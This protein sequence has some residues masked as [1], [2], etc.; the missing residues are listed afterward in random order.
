MAVRIPIVTDFDGKGLE[1]AFKAFKELETTGQKATFALKQAFIPATIALAGLTTGLTMA[2]KAAAEDDRAQ[3]ELERQI[4]ATTSATQEQVAASSD[5]IDTMQLQFAVADSELRP[6]LASLVRGSHDLGQAQ[7]DLVTVLDVSAATGKSVTEV[8]DAVS[9]AYAGNT[10]ALKQ[11]SPELYALIKDGASVD[12]VMQSL[13]DTMGG[14]ATAA[15]NSAEGQMKRL[16]LAFGEA[17]ESIGRAFLPVLEALLP[18][19]T[20]LA[21]IAQNNAPLI[22]GL[23][24]ALGVLAGGIVAAN[25]ALTAW[26]AVGVITTGI[27]YALATSFT[28]VQVATGIGI[29]AVVA[30]IGA[31]ALYKRELD[32]VKGAAAGTNLMP[33]GGGFIG[34]QVTDLPAA[35]QEGFWERRQKITGGAGAVSEA[36]DKMG[37]RIA[38]AR[39]EIQD[40]FNK[41]L[42]EAN[43]KLAQ[44][45][46]AY[47][48]YAK[49][50]SGSV[51]GTL[52]FT[53]ALKEATDAAGTTGKP[54]SFLGGLTVMAER[55]KLFGERI[56]TLLKMGLSESALRQVA[57]A[58]VEAG[59]YIA[60][61]L[62]NGGSE[63]IERTNELVASLESVADTLGIEAADQFYAAGV[64]QGEALVAGIQS[65]ID[66]Y[67]AILANPNL[68]L[69]QIKA[70]GAAA[71]ASL[72]E[73][74]IAP[75][76][77]PAFDV[78][79]FQRN[80]LGDQ[81]N[82]SVYGGLN[83][84]AEQGRAV[85]DAI[86]AAN[87]ADGPA[88]ILV[89]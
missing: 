42:D 72:S 33:G 6:A 4:Q 30:G 67:N 61:Q 37:Q 23:A 19:L 78:G 59:T 7:K 16:G 50:V 66:N 26:K 27:N 70:I 45:K 21:S 89:R 74:I 51:K 75:P 10:K 12:Q 32:K 88:D 34:P 39:K 77:A 48:N 87:R 62:I 46:D 85:I 79:E 18:L 15:A 44:A 83:S 31:L 14:A 57:D 54:V 28:A 80:R 49:E 35:L 20:N 81:Y 56:R 64:R 63:A 41:A 76:S 1:R 52:S 82:I 58:G 5:F 8:A 73:A 47:N 60:D 25:L 11:L 84:S 68:T 3:A 71:D 17:K 36:V 69:P 22:T 43:R 55:S 13:S 24:T 65:V 29:A 86:K 53:D 38:A 2:A 40:R 9:K